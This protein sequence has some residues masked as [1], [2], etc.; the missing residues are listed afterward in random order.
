MVRS[1]SK[2]SSLSG[3]GAGGCQQDVGDGAQPVKAQQPVGVGG[4]GGGSSAQ[5]VQLR[6][7]IAPA[8]LCTV[9]P[10]GTLSQH[11]TTHPPALERSM[12]IASIWSANC[13]RDSG[14]AK[15][16]G[17]SMKRR[18][19]PAASCTQVGGWGG[20]RACELLWLCPCV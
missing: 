2:L 4:G 12:L 6:E 14:L 17:A 11:Y 8:W 16:L 9:C 13:F 10:L 20:G 19:T 15:L 18:T 5:G 1:R 3:W 7:L